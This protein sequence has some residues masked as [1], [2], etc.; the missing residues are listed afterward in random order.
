MYLLFPTINGPLWMRDLF[1]HHCQNWTTPT[2]TQ[3]KKPPVLIYFLF[4]VDAFYFV[5]FIEYS[6]F[7]N[8]FIPK[9]ILLEFQYHVNC[10]VVKRHSKIISENSVQ[11]NFYHQRVNKCT[12]NFL[13]WR[14]NKCWDFIFLL[15]FILSLYVQCRA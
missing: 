3:S 7:S 10:G 8:T 1:N 9:N 11:S 13:L 12:E 15:F 14:N 6:L 5:C 2:L 4:C